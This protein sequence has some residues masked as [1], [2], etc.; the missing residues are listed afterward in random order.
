ML[1]LGQPLGC[2]TDHGVP[3][4]R[5]QIGDPE[6]GEGGKKAMLLRELVFGRYTQFPR[7]AKA[8]GFDFLCFPG[9]LDASMFTKMALWNTIDIRTAEPT[10]RV[11]ARSGPTLRRAEATSEGVVPLPSAFSAHST[12]IDTTGTGGI[13]V[14]P[15][16]LFVIDTEANLVG[17]LASIITSVD[18]NGAF[19][20]GRFSRP[21]SFTI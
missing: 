6:P 21:L 16:A 12:D 15:I 7:L 13:I 9:D 20:I 17:R 4:R 19:S 10:S 1:G 14:F 2:C 8:T 18:G 3:T 5:R 11:F